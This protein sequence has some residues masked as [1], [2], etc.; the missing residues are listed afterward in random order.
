MGKPVGVTDLI[1]R[2]CGDKNL[3]GI[4]LVCRFFY[5][6]VQDGDI[7]LD[8]DR[9]GWNWIDMPLR[10]A[11]IK[12]QYFMEER[13]IED[14]SGEPYVLEACPGCGGDL[15]QVAVRRPEYLDNSGDGA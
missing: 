6:S 1:G 7:L 11:T 8:R 2:R 4:N 13:D 14:H 12:A 10:K 9:G 3:R 15:P 5:D